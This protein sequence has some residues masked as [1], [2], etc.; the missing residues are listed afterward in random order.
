MSS[1]SKAASGKG[2]KLNKKETEQNKVKR[3][4]K[5]LKYFFMELKKYLDKSEDD[6]ILAGQ[7]GN[8]G[9]SKEA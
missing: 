3:A 4:E 1:P 2:G 8:V 6:F 5:N 9:Q 7:K